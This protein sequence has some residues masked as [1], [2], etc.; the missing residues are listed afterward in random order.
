LLFSQSEAKHQVTDR[1]FKLDSPDTKR[2]DQIWRLAQPYLDTRKN[3]IHTRI[4]LELAR[5]LMK[6]EGGQSRVIIPAVILHDVGWKRIPEDQQL[7]AF[8]PGADAP[9]LNRAHELEGV[10][11]A[12]TLLEKVSY[13]RLL[14][15]EILAII[16]GH[17]S[18]SHALSK[19]DA[20]VKDADKLW[21][22]TCEGFRI[23]TERFGET[24]QE[25]LARLED[26][27]Q[28]W[29]LTASGVKFAQ[30]LLCRVRKKGQRDD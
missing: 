18:R 21:R 6:T 27:L 23:D 16:D 14:T 7:K 10:K 3:D 15:C 26:H 13:D 28:E 12:R 29:F 2:Y 30:A 20:V 1:G 25:G 5:R 19:N 8:G 17:D 11:I 24:L 22:Y 4:S 9:E